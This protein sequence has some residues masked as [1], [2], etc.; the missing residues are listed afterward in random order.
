M[1]SMASVVVD[2]VDLMELASG[3]SPAGD[4]ED[5]AFFV[6]RIEARIGVG[7]KRTLVEPKSPAWPLARAVSQ[8]LKGCYGFCPEVGF[9]SNW[10]IV[11]QHYPNKNAAAAAKHRSRNCSNTQRGSCCH[12][13]GNLM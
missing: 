7:L 9:W 5:C 2:E 8:T 4:F 3:M 13:L 10:H 11:N 6:E 1:R 12:A